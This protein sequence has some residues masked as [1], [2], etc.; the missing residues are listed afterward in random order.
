[1]AT[2]L[3]IYKINLN[4][5]V[6]LQN[7][8]AK[9][10]QLP[11]GVTSAKWYCW[12]TTIGD[13]SGKDESNP[14][15]LKGALCVYSDAPEAPTINAKGNW[16]VGGEDL[17]V[18]ATGPKGDQG[19]QGVPGK[20]G[21]DGTNGKDGAQGPQGEKGE[22]GPQGPKGDP[23]NTGLQGPEGPQGPAGPQGPSGP[24][25]PKGDPGKDGTGVSVKGK[26]YVKVDPVVG[27][28]YLIYSDEEYN[29]QIVAEAIGDA[30]LSANTETARAGFLFVYNGDA[31]NQF[32]CA[33]HIS[34]TDGKDGMDGKDGKT[35]QVKLYYT[36]SYRANYV[37]EAPAVLA[38]G[39][40]PAKTVAA[41]KYI[42][43]V[44]D[45]GEWATVSDVSSLATVINTCEVIYTSNCLKY[46]Y[47]GEEDNAL[48]GDWTPPV[49]YECFY[50]QDARDTLNIANGL[51]G[52]G[53][54]VYYTVAEE[55]AINGTIY[56][57]G[58]DVPVEIVRSYLKNNIK[59]NPE[60]ADLFKLY[61]NAEYIKSG[62]LTVL[63]QDGTEKI[64]EAGL[65]D[66]RVSIGGF[67]V[68][69][70]SL[71]S[72]PATIDENK[73]G[74]Y[75]GTDGIRVGS[76]TDY[77]KIK[78]DGSGIIQG[79]IKDALKGDTG[80][81][82][83]QG[84]KGDKGDPGEKGDKGDPGDTGPQG[85]QGDKGQDG[86]GVAIK[87][88][89][90]ECTSIGDGYIDDNGHL[91]MLVGFN[92]SGVA[93]FKDCGEIRG[94]RGPK[95][96]T[97]ATGPQG[98]EGPKG[99][100]GAPGTKGKD[101]TDAKQIE[102][103]KMQYTSTDGTTPGSSTEWK[104]APP[105]YVDGQVYW[106]RTETKFYND[107]NLYYSDPVKDTYLN[108]CFTEIR[109]KSKV[110]YTPNGN[111]E[112]ADP[113]EG[114][115]WFIDEP[116]TLKQW[117]GNEWEDIG[118]KVV[119]KSVT[120][121][122]I[123]AFDIL[124]KKIVV[125]NGNQVLLD[126]DATANNNYVKIG[127][128][129]V[130]AEA[131]E[132]GALGGTKYVHVGTDGIILGPNGE[133]A[134]TPEGNVTAANLTLTGYATVDEVQVLKDG[135]SSVG[136][137]AESKSRATWSSDAPI[138]PVNGDLWYDTS[139]GKT[140]LYQ[141]A[142][143]GWQLIGGTLVA[144]NVIANTITTDWLNTKDITAKNLKV[145]DADNKILFEANGD[146]KTVSVAGFNINN[147]SLYN[148]N[149][150]NAAG[151]LY[152]YYMIAPDLMNS[153]DKYSAWSAASGHDYVYAGTDGLGVLK[154]KEE[155]ALDKATIEK[156]SYLKAGELFSNAGQI[157][158]WYIG[159]DFMGD[160]NSLHNTTTGMSLVENSYTSFGADPNT[161]DP[162]RIWSGGHWADA[163]LND[164]AAPIYKLKVPAFYVTKN[165][166][167]HS[168]SG[169]IAG[170]FFNAQAMYNV[171]KGNVS[172][173]AY[174]TYYMSAPDTVEIDE[175]SSVGGV[176][177]V[178]KNLLYVGPEG[179]GSATLEQYQA[180]TA[181]WRLK[182]GKN[183]YFRQGYLY[184]DDARLTNATIANGTLG[185]LHFTSLLGDTEATSTIKNVTLTAASLSSGDVGGWPISA[186]VMHSPKGVY[187]TYKVITTSDTGPKTENVSG[188]LFTILNT[189]GV[190]FCV[191][192]LNNWDS[193]TSATIV[194]NY[195]S[196][197]SVS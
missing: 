107:T 77:I 94:P 178:D 145:L 24:Q 64:F 137:T 117:N 95:G 158:G 82:G 126:A 105:D 46:Y 155:T 51:F 34:G 11:E 36:Y 54:G 169:D 73:A 114:D 143:K 103:V 115:M 78:A 33:G 185:T 173:S 140:S 71:Y 129:N 4:T 16:S 193:T 116:A 99:D 153:L 9:A 17:G 14:I 142:N 192:L 168:V 92:T 91:Q 197:V 23:G 3:P 35:P 47:E 88:S 188:Y 97:G 167:L 65:A 170:L 90:E 66:H 190:Q 131:F 118:G 186:G 175:P 57:P 112:P 48:Y 176:S 128:F 147:K 139:D 43:E 150:Y 159:K 30:Y 124:A 58:E 21:A 1:M 123:N 40:F 12:D 27:Q 18:A 146:A 165:G 25:G 49:M 130:T 93:Q 151:V 164:A 174:A 191:K 31:S 144:A 32:T 61:I 68:D 141:W 98:P 161:A 148:V 53:Q 29:T 154:I 125:K 20:D 69:K 96:D 113:N 183:S 156:Q 120:A 67:T 121:E 80:A 8:P 63:S 55:T 86:T 19:P 157:G 181:T 60:C 81:I 50:N 41:N 45:A 136:E 22:I 15:R 13:N 187:G 70:N 179:V 110:T 52:Y 6:Q 182:M 189:T 100:Q 172:S 44:V 109:G 132:S 194:P 180:G 26:C 160:Y 149:T 83:A 102:Y 38:T 72:G 79:T 108:Q 163:K 84:E 119:A 106:T 111:T 171:L 42:Y 85:P 162:P 39:T 166:Y 75:I 196:W 7:D 28:S 74:V 133:F 184:S 76:D 152:S 89:K 59:A 5:L 2:P 56:R 10:F 62:A 177:A 87:A 138:N 195:D 134:V 37:E 122:Y 101:G 135:L 104:Y 127:G